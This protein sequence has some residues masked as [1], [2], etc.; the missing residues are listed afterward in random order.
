MNPIIYRDDRDLDLLARIGEMY[1]I[2]KRTQ[3]EIAEILGL[4][5]S[6]VSRLLQAAR[7]QGVVQIT[8]QNPTARL[9]ELAENLKERFGLRECRVCPN[10]TDY[11]A[12][13]SRLGYETSKV[14]LSCLE[15]GDVFGIGPSSTVHRAVE[16]LPQTADYVCL[17]I[18][19]LSGGSSRAREPQINY[20]V[21]LAA[22]RLNADYVSLNVPLYLD[23]PLIAA[24]LMEETAVKRCT[25]L[26]EELACALVGIGAINVAE[27]GSGDVRHILDPA[28]ARRTTAAVCGWFFNEHGETVQGKSTT[29]IN[30]SQLKKT[31]VVVAVAGGR[32][33]SAAVLSVLRAGF[34]THLITDEMV[35][36]TILFM[37][38]QKRVT[39]R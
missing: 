22:T 29:S 16:L 10:E 32:G 25:E 39:S 26:W 2:Q 27:P 12:L 35:A 37:T 15:S 23:E 11:D 33:K 31:P 20:T 6:A 14:L 30:V 17:I 34:V 5:R 4:S 24:K 21:Q 9:V 38:Q 28:V 36:K 19:P 8:V 13:K 7:D 3:K 1:Y 18:V